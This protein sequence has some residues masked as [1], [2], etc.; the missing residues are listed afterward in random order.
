M[1]AVGVRS[2]LY[3]WAIESK[4][5]GV[6]PADL[7]PIACGLEDHPDPTQAL[8]TSGLIDPAGDEAFKIH[9]WEQYAGRLLESRA[10]SAERVRRYRDRV[11]RERNANVTQCNGYESVSNPGPYPTV[12]NRTV[13]NRTIPETERESRQAE[14][15]IGAAAPPGSGVNSEIARAVTVEAIAAW[16]ADREPHHRIRVT[17]GRV[18]KVKARLADGFTREQ[19][20]SVV[21][22]VKRSA[23]HTGANPRGWKAPG[24]EWA[25]HTTERV[26]QWLSRPEAE[27]E[28][29]F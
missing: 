17:P 8:V 4:P 3:A 25:L 14:P 15:A 21:E 19:I 18:A 23:F 5:D 2:H 22:R 12:P 7:I 27:E 28:D 26:E 9:D 6:I 24:P 20:L 13:P 11:L 10:R 1:E 29:L 16:N